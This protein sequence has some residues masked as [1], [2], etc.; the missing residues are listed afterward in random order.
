VSEVLVRFAGREWAIRAGQELTFGRGRDRDIRFGHDPLDDHVSRAA[1]AIGLGDGHLRVRNDSAT[2]PV[3]LHVPGSRREIEPGESVLLP[4]RRDVAV[5][6][7]G[8]FDARYELRV[9]A[10]ADPGEQ[11]PERAQAPGSPETAATGPVR[12]TVAQRRV[13][14]ALCEP[15][16]L[17]SAPEPATYRQIGE[18]LG[19]APG[20]VRNVLKEVRES[21][22]GAGVPGL[23]A[24]GPHPAG[25]REDQAYDF[26]RPLAMWAL[27]TAAVG[28]ADLPA[29]DADRG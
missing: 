22:A 17:G 26:R 10:R 28:P 16:L 15:L 5:V 27:R 11:P 2:R 9:A 25:A 20:H 3:L 21:L 19:R 7:V 1:G 24:A 6:V 18:R 12:L 4:A 29:L 14:V 8:A 23:L 13:L